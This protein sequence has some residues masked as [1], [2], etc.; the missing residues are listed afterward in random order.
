MALTKQGTF[1]DRFTTLTDKPNKTATEMKAL[2]ESQPAE[3][4]TTLNN[5]LDLLMATTDGASG[6]DNIGVTAITGWAGV[7]PQAILESAKT[8]VDGK[9]AKTL[10]SAQGDMLYASGAGTPAKLAKGT[11]GQVLEM[12]PGATA[13]QWGNT[14]LGVHQADSA[15]DIKNQGAVATLDST[16]AVQ[17]SINL[18]N[19]V[20]V[21]FGKYPITAV[22]NKYGI[23]FEGIGA[24]V[25]N[26]V[27][28]IK[29]NSLSKKD[30][31]F[32]LE[33]LS[34]FHKKIMARTSAF[35]ILKIV[36]S[37]DSTTLGTSIVDPNNTL[38]NLMAF[39]CKVKGIPN[40]TTINNGQSGMDTEHWNQTYY[41]TDLTSA[42]DVL[43]LR[44]GL[45]DPGLSIATNIAL[46]SVDVITPALDAQRRGV[47]E[48]TTSLRAGLTKVRASKTSTQ[49][50]IILMTPNSTSDTPN[51]RN[52]IWHES[53]NNV[54]RQAARD[55]QCVFID[56]YQLFQDS[57]NAP[58]SNYM[59]LSYTGL[60]SPLRHV[61]PLDVMNYWITSKIF[62]VLFPTAILAKFGVNNVTNISSAN[63][64]KSVNDLPSTYP[65][66]ISMYRCLDAPFSGELLTFKSADDIVYQINSGYIDTLG[67]QQM[68]HRIK[69]MSV[70][71]VG[72][73]WGGWITATPILQTPTLTNS[74]TNDVS[75]WQ[76]TQYYKDNNNIVHIQGRLIGGTPGT[77]SMAF[78]L[79]A[80]F[81]PLGNQMFNIGSNKVW[82]TKDGWVVM[83]SGALP[84][85]LGGISFFAEH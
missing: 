81:M 46:G 29:V 26:S 33:Y 74:W 24:I 37:G 4:K 53:I 14:A 18:G 38:S 75:P 20:N 54:I 47:I 39:M 80:G 62:D 44:W 51:R 13:P 59:D 34:Y 85:D 50:S 36:F 8:D 10:L 43:V 63:L 68:A 56:T 3:L 66:G 27:D 78:L 2:F 7:T 40:V 69:L 84:F 41:N 9:I 57:R 6:A 72:D 82:V 21:P 71:G 32:G 61:H 12:N 28:E 52:E 64:I 73:T 76:A 31:I 79:P 67:L 11:A 70:S 49:M 5:A 23:P 16:T 25:L 1:I 42:P 60:P 19:N 48:F 45:N 58:A 22:D 77:S 15:T 65:Y 35:E 30:L 55:F 83:Y 17:N